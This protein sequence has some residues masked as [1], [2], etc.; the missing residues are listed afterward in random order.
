MNRGIG[1]EGRRIEVLLA[2][3]IVAEDCDFRLHLHRRL[4]VAGAIAGYA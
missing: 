4:Q 2:G 1:G 3:A